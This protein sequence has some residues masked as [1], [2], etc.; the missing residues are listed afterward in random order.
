MSQKYAFVAAQASSYPVTV[1]C[2]VLGLAR[3]GFYAWKRRQTSARAAQDATLT[4]Q[5]A[6]IFQASRQTYG[7]PR[8]Q[9]ALRADGVRISRKRV[10]RLMHRARLVARRRGARPH[11]TDSRHDQPLAPNL[12]ARQFEASAPNQRWLADITYLATR[13]GWLYLA[14]VLD[15]FARRAVG[16]ATAV[17]LER[18]LVLAALDDALQRRQPPAGLLHHSDRGSQYA[19]G[20]YQARLAQA[21]CLSSMSRKGNCWDNAP[22][23]SFFATLKAEIGET[24]FGSQA[25][26]RTAVFDYIERFY[27]RQRRHSTLGYDTPASYE[28]RWAEQQNT[29]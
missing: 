1:I 18:Q 3:S 10:A 12:L 7:S 17:T 6:T 29:A 20:D 13:E 24:V 19:S 15:L 28:V 22:M 5:I 21:E 23:E 11:T 27:N 9:A 4:R 8:I 26:A 2:R 14:V 16:W 25:A